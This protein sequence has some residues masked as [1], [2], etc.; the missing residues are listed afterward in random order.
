MNVIELVDGNAGR[1]PDKTALCSMDKSFTFRQVKEKSEQAAAC[2]QALGIKKGDPVAIMSQNS[3]DFVFSFFGILKSGG[4]VVPVNHKL[5]SP[6]VDYILENSRSTLFLFDGSLAPVAAGLTVD[7]PKMSMDT[8]TEGI[9][10]LGDAM[11]LPRPLPLF[12]S[13]MKTGLKSCIP[14]AP[15]A[16]PKAVST[17]IKAWS[18]PASPAPPPSIWMK[19]T[20]CS[21]PCPSGTPH[22]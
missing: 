22:P 18:L 20:P 6:E 7:I 14:A 10:F 5:T 3:F 21:L 17:P 19:P 16:S 13:W 8:G 11:G 4:V 12:P 1:H 2:F 15:P 9:P